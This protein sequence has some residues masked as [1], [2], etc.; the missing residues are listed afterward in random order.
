M[1]TLADLTSVDAWREGLG[2]IAVPLQYGELQRF[3]ML[4]GSRGNFCLDL[5]ANP[6]KVDARSTA[7]SADVGHYVRVAGDRITVQRWDRSRLDIRPFDTREVAAALSDFQQYLEQ[8]DPTREASIVRFITRVY[9]MLRATLGMER[10]PGESLQ[11][12]LLLLACDL[13]DRDRSSI[14]VTNFGIPQTALDV[15]KRITDDQWLALI[16]E[17]RATSQ[18]GLRPNLDYVLRHAAGQVFQDAHYMAESPDSALEPLPGMLRAPAKV[19][20]PA[21]SAGVFFTPPYLARTLVEQAMHALDLRSLQAMTIFD[22]ACG[23]G[24]ILREAVRQLELQKFS[25]TVRVIGWDASE[26]ACQMARFTMEW[27]RRSTKLKLEILIETRDSLAACTAWP[28]NV[29][30]ILMNPPFVSYEFLPAAQR[31]QMRELLGAQLGQRPDLAAAFLCLAE[32][33]VARGGVIAA[34]VPAS[35]L[36]NK[37]TQGLREQLGHLSP[38]FIA[39]LGDMT[40]FSNA[41]VDAG[42]YVG[43]NGQY[44]TGKMLWSSPEKSALTA[45]LR[46]LRRYDNAVISRDYFSIYPIETLTS[47]SWAPRPYESLE[48]LKAFADTNATVG[49]LFAVHQGVR[50]G[51]RKVFVLEDEQFYALPR[52]ERKYFRDTIVNRSIVA[53]RIVSPVH[54]F[55]PYDAQAIE[56][57]DALRRAVPTYAAQY[58]FPN[59]TSLQ[60][61]AKVTA[62][63]W[64]KLTWPRKG[65]VARKIISKDFGRRGAFAFDETGDRLVMSGYAWHPRK[66]AQFTEEVALAYVAILNSELFDQLLGATSRQVSGGQWYLQSRFVEPLPMPDLFSAKASPAILADLAKIGHELH[67]GKTPDEASWRRAVRQAYEAPAV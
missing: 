40:L 15:A 56:S 50:T 62:E 65:D 29:Q 7:W 1:Q 4:N 57:E 21:A 58:L 38:V 36:D 47:E 24:E 6:E 19:T 45:A 37:T 9:G 28:T 18:N 48:R 53:S 17:L 22:P 33:N 46:M 61:R 66:G 32:R 55:F 20:T 39:K 60:K 35:L 5:G 11:A 64:W 2:L 16:A 30:A 59:K 51:D 44:S 42:M 41:L 31:A 34:I 13:E 49:K 43:I 52:A 23:S 12:F 3:V 54:M 67:Q 25:G 10:F 26:I 8:H 27:E 63:K 14:D